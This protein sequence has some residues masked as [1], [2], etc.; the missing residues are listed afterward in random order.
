MASSNRVKSEFETVLGTFV[1]L[2]GDGEGVEC[3]DIVV[4]MVAGEAGSEA[5]ETDI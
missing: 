1:F 4:A 5:F 2:E 3:E